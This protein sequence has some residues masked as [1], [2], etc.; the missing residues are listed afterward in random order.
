MT[1]KKPALSRSRATKLKRKVIITID[2]PAAS[3]KGTAA[4]I[5]AREYGLLNLDSG[6]CYRAIAWL[7]LEHGISLTEENSPKL[8][9]L[10][11][12]NPLKLTPNLTGEGPKCFVFVGKTEITHLIRTPEVGNAASVVGNFQDIR[13]I[14][15]EHE[16]KIVQQSK[17]GI[18]VEGRDSGTVVFPEAEIK[19]FLTAAPEERAARRHAEYEVAGKNLSYEQVLAEIVERDER[20]TNRAFSAL[21]I[22]Q[23]AL[24]VD[25]TNLAVEQTLALMREHIEEYLNG[26]GV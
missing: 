3:G 20:D 25:S 13:K 14:V 10:L 17:V 18:V 8:G 11:A 7:S 12:Q 1:N 4:Y 5:L 9:E 15:R 2:G 19:F 21:R 6:A 22:P 23:D 16:H 24:V 26:V